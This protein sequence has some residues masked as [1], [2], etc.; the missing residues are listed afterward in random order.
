[1]KTWGIPPARRLSLRENGDSQ[2]WKAMKH[3]LLPGL[4]FL[5]QDDLQVVEL[6]N[7][8]RKA[9]GAVS[10][11]AMPDKASSEP[12]TEGPRAATAT[13]AESTRE[14]TGT[15]GTADPDLGSKDAIKAERKA[16]RDAYKAEC[17]AAGVKL[18][19]SMIGLE[20][21]RG[22]KD[23]RTIVQQWM[24]C[25]PRYE[26]YDWPIRGVFSRKPHLPKKT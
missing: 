2:E 10:D 19:D 24:R 13:R 5:T 20:V 22:S 17:R 8:A 4:K 23:P 21:K 18:T 3:T 25:D 9:S 7:A 1:V 12:H 15:S 11:R 14:T 16:R 26:I 6:L